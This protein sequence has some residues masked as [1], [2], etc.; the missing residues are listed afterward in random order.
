LLTTVVD[1]LKDLMRFWDECRFLHRMITEQRP[2]PRPALPL[3]L[4]R[5]QLMALLGGTA[6]AISVLLSSAFWIYTA[7]PSGDVAVIEAGLL[8]SFFAA[9]DNSAELT[10]KFLKGTVV[11]TAIAGVYVLFILPPINGMVPLIIAQALFY[12]PCGVMLASSRQAPTVLP[13]I[14]GFTTTVVIQ[15]NYTM[16][17]DDFLNIAI[18]TCLGVAAAAIILRLFRSVGRDWIIR[19]LVDATHRDLARIAVS[20]QDMDRSL[21]EGRMFDRLNGLLMRRRT[22]E[23]QDVIRG[24]LAALRIGLNLILFQ[25]VEGSLS[26]PARRSGRLARAELARLFHRR[27]SNLQQL[28]HACSLLQSAVNDVAV[29]ALT[30]ETK[31]AVLALGAVRL[32]LLGH[33][34][35]FCRLA[36][37][38]I[39][40]TQ[41]MVMA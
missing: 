10:I 28:Q 1:R 5:D 30:P 4:Y 25:A 24:S 26:L 27:H 36:P 7:W 35:F 8:C 14:I 17:F 29:E 19:R 21:F 12:L 38:D 3:A 23:Q 39:V 41:E 32:L 18:A 15:N 2:A 40:T 37:T 9:A 34:A 22:D 33:A 31:Q 20:D 11:G 6:A 13:V 16:A